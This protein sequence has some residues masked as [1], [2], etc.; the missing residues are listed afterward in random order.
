MQNLGLKYINYCPCCLSSQIKEHGSLIAPFFSFR[1]LGISPVQT[2]EGEFDDLTTGVSYL[3][4]KTIYCESCGSVSCSARFTEDSMMRYYHGYQ[5][6]E[7]LEM[8]CRLEPSFRARLNNR[9]NQNTLRKR[10]ESVQY[11][12]IIR[13]WVDTKISNTNFE[14][15]LD[16][17][18]GT[19]SNTPLLGS[20][21]THVWDIDSTNLDIKYNFISIM[22]V[23]EHVTDP[24]SLLKIASEKLSSENRSYILIEVPLERF[25]HDTH[26]N[27]NFYQRK[28]V[29]TEHIN[30]FSTAGLQ[31][32][33][34]NAGLFMVDSAEVLITGGAS[35]DLRENNKVILALCHN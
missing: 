31:E 15:V 2:K 5:N 13:S 20:I 14:H 18:G 30:C 22:N 16:Y 29:W 9:S 32:C 34:R 1:A 21:S 27:I 12:K 3:P 19:G 28:K 6:E 33:V 7:F 10:G 17:G 24:V 23:L 4:V 26:A 35:E 11:T 8:R 25:M